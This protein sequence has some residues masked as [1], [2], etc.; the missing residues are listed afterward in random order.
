MLTSFA[1][2]EISF[3]LLLSNSINSLAALAIDT[4]VTLPLAASVC[5]LLATMAKMA[6]WPCANGYGYGFFGAHCQRMLLT[7][8]G[9]EGRQGGRK[10]QIYA[11]KMMR[12]CCKQLPG[13]IV[14]ICLRLDWV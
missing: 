4:T 14:P 13:C 11:C 12:T 10:R 7:S 1:V 8:C 2:L 6:F 3:L 9:Q 5:H